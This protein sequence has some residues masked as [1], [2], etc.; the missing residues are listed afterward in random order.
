MKLYLQCLDAEFKLKSTPSINCSR[1]GATVNSFSATIEGDLPLAEDQELTG[2]IQWLSDDDFMLREME[3]SDFNHYDINRSKSQ[4][5]VT[6]E[7]D[8]EGNQVPV[9]PEDFV[10]EVLST[11]LYFTTQPRPEP[12]Q[13]PEPYIPDPAMLLAQ[14]KNMRAAPIITMRDRCIQMGIDV[15]TEYG[16]EHFSLEERDKTMLLAIYAMVQGGM[17][18]FPY[19]SLGANDTTNMCV[20]YSDT[21]IGKI[22]VA[23]FSYI[24]FH[25]SYANMLSQ[26]LERVEDLDEARTIQYGADLPED[27]QQYLE[28]VMFCASNAETV[29]E[30]MA[31][32][33]VNMPFKGSDIKLPDINGIDP[34]TGMPYMR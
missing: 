30:M 29:E 4:P 17:S 31:M 23:A 33:P 8:G 24:T 6:Y 15:E 2:T 9:V 3:V 21:D 1:D 14:E 28:M 18:Q 27:L 11:S 16:V 13:P 5:P 7:D 19:H 25:E 26:W 20:V 12:V 10:P 34:N 32:L 22:A